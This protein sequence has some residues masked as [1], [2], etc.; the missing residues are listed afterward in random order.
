MLD[1]ETSLLLLQRICYLSFH[2][3]TAETRW[4]SERPAK[5]GPNPHV[6]KVGTVL[7]AFPAN[8]GVSRVVVEADVAGFQS[9]I[10]RRE[11]QL[12]ALSSP[13]SATGLFDLTDSQPNLLLP[14]ENLGAWIPV[15]GQT[16]VGQWQLPLPDDATSPG[17]S[18]SARNPIKEGQITNMLFVISYSDQTQV[19]PIT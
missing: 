12:V 4:Q 19:W 7:P 14:F 9:V 18:Q 2:L 5:S 1:P 16:V 3:G 17:N 11:P 10:V 8:P 13:S 15:R 6:R